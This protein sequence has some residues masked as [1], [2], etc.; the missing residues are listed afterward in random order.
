MTVKEL[1][2]LLFEIENQEAEIYVTS[3]NGEYITTEI[4]IDTKDKFEGNQIIKLL[5]A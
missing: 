3:S 1:R 5:E 2:A 4:L